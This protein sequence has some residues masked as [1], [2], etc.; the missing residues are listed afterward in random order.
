VTD[1]VPQVVAVRVRRPVP[2]GLSVLPGS[3]PVVSFGDP[4]TATVATLSLNPSWLEFQSASGAW[5]LGG[6]RR[7][8][9]LVSLGADDPRDLDDA[10]VAQ[11][12]ADSNAYFRGNW[13]RGW[14]HW[15]ESLLQESEAGSYL[16]GS[17]CHL[18]LVQGATK[19]AHG[20][21]PASVWRRLVERD[22][23]FLRWQLGNSNVDVVLLNGAS[24][25]RWAQEAGL[26]GGFDEDALVYQASDGHGTI[27]VSR[28]VAE[29]VSFLG[30]NRPLAGALAADGRRRLTHWVGRVLRK[31]VSA[32]DEDGTGPGGEGAMAAA[33]LVNGYVPA[34]TIVHGAA[35]L[36]CV[37]AHWAEASNQATLGDVG[38][39]GGSAVVIIRI[40]RDE[41]V[42]N[43]DTKRAAVLAF[44]GAAANRRRRRQ[45]ALARHREQ[46]GHDQPS[47]LP[48]GRWSDPGLVR[49]PAHAEPAT[50]GAGVTGQAMQVVQFVHPGF[51]YHRAEH[52][53]GRNTRSGVMPWKPGRSQHDRKFMLT[54]G[55]LFDPGAGEDHRSAPLCFWGEWEGPSVFWRV[56]SPG[57]PLP[58]IVH[59]PYRPASWPTAPVQNTDPMVFGEAF[60]Y[61]NCLQGAYRSLRTLSPGSIVLFGRYA[62][63]QGRP[64]FS[65]DTCLVI[66]RVQTLT[67]APVEPNS[68]G[69][70]L[71]TDAVLGPLFTEDVEGDLS[72]YF[73]RRRPLGGAGP[74][75]FFPARLVVDA[76]PMFARPELSPAGVLDGVISP[77][78]M[79][80]IKLTSQLSVADR[81]A[82]WAEIVAQ[83]HRQGCG[84]GHYATPPP[85]L[86]PH[87]AESAALLAPAVLGP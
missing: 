27:R 42:L 64:S 86:E 72:V 74:F 65:L 28:A 22:R 11:V 78:N 43:R 21:L 76:P 44:L 6:R 58:R 57:K 4:N 59:A 87:A 18:D 26:V 29:G 85:L 73:G 54:R 8:A 46:Q 13:Y 62:R 48:P 25:V 36:E 81:D 9:S 71:L 17:A 40:G 37:L 60:I 30:W 34:G 53:R 68:Y 10:Q 38:A 16:D 80:G 19:P 2:A 61:S 50:A 56:D 35:E 45:A 63:T 47:Q 7:L 12:V 24:V 82:I 31:R 32:A 3:L 79:Q 1:P 5:L 14:F 49:L 52:V 39:F 15:L 55:S 84:L 20:E 67:P 83:V 69:G 66:D 23:D 77:G 41:F 70:D 33:E 51:E 75:S